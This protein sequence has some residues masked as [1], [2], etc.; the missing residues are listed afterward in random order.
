MF[1]IKAVINF[2]VNSTMS[3]FHQ[4]SKLPEI[5][6]LYIL[7]FTDIAT[8]KNI[9]SMPELNNL[10]SKYPNTERLFEER[11]RIHF[12]KYISF[13]EENMKWIEFYKRVCNLLPYIDSFKTNLKDDDYDGYQLVRNNRLME[14]KICAECHGKYPYGNNI[15]SA[16]YRGHLDILKWAYNLKIYI[17]L[18]FCT[19]GARKNIIENLNW[20]EET[21]LIS[22]PLFPLMDYAT[23]GTTEALKWLHKRNL[24]PPPIS[25]D[26]A[27]EHGNLET[28]KW[29]YENLNY[30][31]DVY[32][33][34]KSLKFGHLHITEWLNSKI[35]DYKPTI[36]AAIGAAQIG[37][38]NSLIWLEKHG[39]Y[40]DSEIANIAFKYDQTKILNWLETKGIKPNK[41]EKL[42][43]D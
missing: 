13:K 9:Y 1:R 2:S 19:F 24:I 4:F 28:L 30:P 14:L 29:M 5:C 10:H 11:S 20:Y 32:L 40:S 15:A 25:M 27:T 41:Y 21:G 23:H 7:A 18:D 36:N 34:D 43:V 22:Q 6:Q 8:F 37:N 12:A 31:L 3:N 33:I 17:D 38:L 42:Y 16:S 39:I 35:I 26:Y